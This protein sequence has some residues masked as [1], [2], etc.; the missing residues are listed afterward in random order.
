M[1]GGLGLASLFDRRITRTR[2][3]RL[4]AELRDLV[5]RVEADRGGGRLF[6]PT[7]ELEWVPAFVAWFAGAMLLALL[8]IGSGGEPWQFSV[9]IFRQ[10]PLYLVGLLSVLGVMGYYVV[11]LN[12]LAPAYLRRHAHAYY[13]HFGGTGV[14]QRHGRTYTFLPWSLVTGASLE[15]G[16]VVA[17]DGTEP[18][19]TLEV[20]LAGHR[21]LTAALVKGYG[22]GVFFQD[23]FE[24]SD[25]DLREME[26]LILAN[27][28]PTTG[29]R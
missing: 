29:A 7:A 6:R 22:P 17:G 19:R 28:R 26:R 8:A 16:R 27:A 1:F 9:Y 4:P 10:N 2:R 20:Q 21:V 25:A 5:E 11:W 15:I 14:L 13:L 12:G 3:G 23:W 18:V 24:Y